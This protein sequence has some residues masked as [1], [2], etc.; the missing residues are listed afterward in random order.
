M[1]VAEGVSTDNDSF[2]YACAGK[3]V[4][5]L[6]VHA[7]EK[8]ARCLLGE[9]DFV[10]ELMCRTLQP[11]PAGGGSGGGGGGAVD[12]GGGGCGKQD[13]GGRGGKG[14]KGEGDGGM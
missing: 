12:G 9:V 10:G 13:G 2:Y 4:A 6:D 11:K 8:N 3:H 7:F 5:R 14:G 1:D